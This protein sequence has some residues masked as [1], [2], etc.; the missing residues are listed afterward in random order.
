MFNFFEQTAVMPETGGERQT[1]MPPEGRSIAIVDDDDAVCDSTRLLLEAYDFEVS[2]YL[3]GSDFLREDPQVG[4]LIVDYQ[5]PGLN[6]LEFVAELRAR[7]SRVPVIM[8]T[9]TSDPTLERR[10]AQ[11]GINRVLQKPLS[12]RVLL[13][14]LRDE[15][16]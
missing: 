7:G 8:I 5:M 10:A 3:R 4:C 2:T 15:L 16:K 6:G 1:A 13:R 9:A 12:S 14:A 11:L